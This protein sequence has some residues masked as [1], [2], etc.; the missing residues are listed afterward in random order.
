MIVCGDGGGG[1]LWMEEDRL[2]WGWGLFCC[3]ENFGAFFVFFEE[4]LG[5]IL[6]DEGTVD[7]A[8]GA[9]GLMAMMRKG[10]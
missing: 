10:W 9:E 8:G 1:V 6:Q 4:A 3:G 5:W 2:S 7:D